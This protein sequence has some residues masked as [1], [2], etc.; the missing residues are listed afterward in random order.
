MV[1]LD[2]SVSFA[3]DFRRKERRRDTRNRSD[4]FPALDYG[5]AV[6]SGGLSICES[7]GE[8]TPNGEPD[9][10]HLRIIAAIMG[11]MYLCI[12]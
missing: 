6:D 5:V 2:A 8:I 1:G 12:A 9:R 7:I 10:R 3:R 4:G 11:R